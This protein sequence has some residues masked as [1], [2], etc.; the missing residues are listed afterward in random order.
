M[1]LRVVVYVSVYLALDPAVAVGQVIE[2]RADLAVV[3]SVFA[4]GALEQGDDDAER[5]GDQGNSYGVA[6]CAVF[7]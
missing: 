7:P 6:H 1:S 2:L 5:A 4:A 3:A